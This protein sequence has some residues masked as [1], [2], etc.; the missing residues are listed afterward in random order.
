MIAGEI[1]AIF[2][3]GSVGFYNKQYRGV[4]Q[5]AGVSPDVS[6]VL[7]LLQNPDAGWDF[8]PTSTMLMFNSTSQDLESN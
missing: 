4:C 1:T 8:P 3:A 2:P 6:D 5:C 7:G